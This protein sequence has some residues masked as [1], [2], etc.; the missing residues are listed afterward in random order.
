M[1]RDGLAWDVLLLDL[2]NVV[3]E[4]ET[5]SLERWMLGRVQGDPLDIR[6]RF[7]AIEDRFER[8]LMDTPAF[9]EALRREFGLDDDDAA[10]HEAFTQCW[11]RDT[12]GMERLLDSLP[13][14][15]GRCVLSNTNALHMDHF[16]PRQPILGRF[17]RFFFSHELGCRKPEPEIYRKTLDALGCEPGRVLYFDDLEPNVEGARA[18]GIDARLFRSTDQIAEALGLSLPRVAESD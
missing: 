1:Q 11:H 5:R 8:G 7:D 2:G 10:M 6:R 17:E 15:L 12:P 9:F 3:F 13:A 14:G 16:L 18:A 4:L